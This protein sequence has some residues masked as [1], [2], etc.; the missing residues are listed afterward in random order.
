MW[1]LIWGVLVVGTL[2]GAFFL[3]RDLFRTGVR[4]ARAAGDAAEVLGA[5]AARIGDAAAAAAANPPDTGPT[6]FD[7][8]VVLRERVTLLRA[9]RAARADA[10]R[11]RW[12]ATA[13]G[14]SLDAWLADRK[15]GREGA[16][17]PTAGRP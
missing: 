11:E 5:A 17:G 1:W 12:W 3:A 10:R 14:W 9:A 16:T 6:L 13:R 2:V 4:L 8:P 15:G 7:D